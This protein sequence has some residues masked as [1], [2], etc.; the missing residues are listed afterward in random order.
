MNLGINRIFSETAF[1]CHCSVLSS[2]RLVYFSSGFMYFNGNLDFCLLSGSSGLM[3]D[4]LR[5]KT[6]AASFKHCLQMEQK[7]LE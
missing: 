1:F 7:L 3:E 4:S 6:S 2:E 5:R